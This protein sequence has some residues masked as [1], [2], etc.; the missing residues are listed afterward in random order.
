MS[1]A[2]DRWRSEADLISETGTSFLLP[3]RVLAVPHP[4]VSPAGSPRNAK[5]IADV[6][7]FDWA[8][9]G[10]CQSANVVMTSFLE[11]APSEAT[12]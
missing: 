4:I 5:R 7:S 8:C 12:V 3:T 6:T 10:S 1:V 9:A 11:S 2:K